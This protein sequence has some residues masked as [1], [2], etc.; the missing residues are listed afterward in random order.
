MHVELEITLRC[1]VKCTA[2]SR[3]CDI[4]DD[5]ASDMTWDTY[6]M[7]RQQAIKRH[8]VGRVTVMG[9]EPTMHPELEE[10]ISDLVLM[11]SNGWIGVVCM[12]TNGVIP[13]DFFVPKCVQVSV[14]PPAIKR[15]RCQLMAPCDTGQVQRTCQV[16]WGC[17]VAVNQY[18]CYPC[19]AGG[20]IARLLKLPPYKRTDLTHPDDFGDLSGLCKYCQA[21]AVEPM[22]VSEHGNVTSKTFRQALEE[23]KGAGDG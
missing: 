8:D 14:V 17:G 6:S 23:S 21:S 1:N 20:A 15:H 22:M 18:G 12:S 7:F 11:K 19:G 10:I 3:H 4:F 16:P 9:G 2:C 5:P 13:L